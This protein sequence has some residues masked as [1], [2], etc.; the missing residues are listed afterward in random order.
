[1]FFG[2]IKAAGC[3]VA[4]CKGIIGGVKPVPENICNGNDF[5]TGI[6]IQGLVGSPGSPSASAYNSHPEG[7]TA[8]SKGSVANS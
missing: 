7:I 6:G 2:N 8:C 4:L 1:M 5:H 3:E